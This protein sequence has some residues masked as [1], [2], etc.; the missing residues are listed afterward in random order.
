MTPGAARAAL[1]AGLLESGA[2]DEQ[3]RSA[4]EQVPRH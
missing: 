3:W 4:F 1:V 2:L